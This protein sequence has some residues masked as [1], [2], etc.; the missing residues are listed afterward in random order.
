MSNFSHNGRGLRIALMCAT[1]LTAAV[2]GAARAEDTAKAA[3]D[4]AKP[5]A[6][7]APADNQV[8]VVTG[9]R[10]SLRSATAAKKD[11]TNFTETIF[12][13]DI[14]KFPDLNLAESM[15]RVPGMVV[16]RDP[17]TGD[18]A[19]ISVRALPSSF[20]LVSMNG[21]RVAVASDFG[22]T[23]QSSPNRQVDLDMFPT[24]LFNRIDVAKTPSADALEGGI[25]G[26][27]NIQ[28]ARPFDR[29]GEHLVFALQD[30][31]NQ[32]ARK[33]SPRLT[34]VASK[35]W[36][37]FG[38]LVGYTSS[39]RK[40][41]SDGFET[42]GWGDPNLSNFC[43]SC[44]PGASFPSSGGFNTGQ[45]I[46]PAG[47]NQ[48]RFS[49]TV[50]GYTGHGLTPGPLSETQLLALNP[51]LTED[52]LKGA[53]L[54]RLGRPY[55][56][57]GTSKNQVG[58][59]ALEYR[60]SSDL[61]F[62]LDILGG[63][64][65]RNAERSDMMW[66]VRNTGPG[67][68]YNGGMIPLNMKVD[69][70][71]VVTSGTFLNSNF[72]EESNFYRDRTAYASVNAGFDWRISDSLKWDG[73]IAKMRSTYER[74]VTFFKMR[75]A[76]QTTLDVT[77]ANVDGNDLPTI[78]PS[79]DLNSPN[80]GWRMFVSN[81]F[82]QRDRRVVDSDSVH[83]NLTWTHGDWTLKGGW[84]QDNFSRDINVYDNSQA[85]R[86]A[87]SAVVSDAT[88]P[89]YLK[90][91]TTPLFRDGVS[92]AGFSKFVTPDFDKLAP[93]IGYDA[94][95][96]AKGNITTGTTYNGAGATSIEEKISAGYAMAS[97]RSTLFGVPTKT[98]FGFRFQTTEQTITSP[99]SVNGQ[100]VNIT[101][102][103]HYKDVL[104]SFNTVAAVTDKLNIR[105]AASK[106]MTRANPSQMTS[107]LGFSDPSAQSASQGNPSLK[108]Y[109]SNNLDLGGE[110]YT[111]K[112]GYVGLT[113]FTKQLTNF[114]ITQNQVVPFTALGIPFTSL[115]GI[116]QCAM[117]QGKTTD[118]CT[119][120]Q[121]NPANYA[122]LAANNSINLSAPINIAKKVRLSG[123][124]FMWVQPLDNFVDGLGYTFNYTNFKFS[125]VHI[126]T[127][128]PDHTYNL[129]GY[130][131]HG[132]FSA[133]V[134]YVNVGKMTIGTLP[135][136]NSIPYDWYQKER[137]QIDLS[138]AY[139]FK[140]FGFDQSLTLDATNLDNQG[141]RSYLGYENV[142]YQF[143]NPGQTII[144]GWRATY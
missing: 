39:E 130:Y 98:N 33:F 48:F 62:T 99:S 24:G 69:S 28:N 71:G 83:T 10:A 53:L 86:N 106:T 12:A 122:S 77:Y 89:Q 144:L 68:D 31:Y 88:L 94:I 19:Q 100:I 11:A 141:F 36:D 102:S 67:D 16:Q 25:A 76:F 95:A 44:D 34:A 92:G 5:A 21:N 70:H 18:G 22:F 8:V 41:F 6:A 82:F 58:L 116:Q 50:Y 120:V 97:N 49:N 23:G 78:T 108:P 42:V 35:T 134:S 81:I 79:V 142:P 96:N 80:I 2:A 105:F 9:F 139:K 7:Q 46:N 91:M 131:E 61:K 59:V 127:G 15:Q 64:A 14:G 37:K 66:A 32:N 143:N 133:H 104:P 90:V 113:L 29:K 30:S 17:L 65:E 123:Q 135:S 40:I 117:V 109:Y 74:D 140:A 52:Q 72:F 54:P 73:E 45:V 84:A 125:D 119:A 3:E 137:H 115:S 63:G 60:P 111:G 26:T 121:A 51:G 124:E 93:A 132:G 20:T 47:S 138:A 118:P 75:T 110:Y 114:A 103:R 57:N 129:T 13:E 4:A 87:Y 1:A 85:L 43:P 56:L 112:T 101:T 128:I 126:L 107:Q 27:V 38:A 136:P 55:F